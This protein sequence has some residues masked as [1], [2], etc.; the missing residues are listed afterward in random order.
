MRVARLVLAFLVVML[1]VGAALPV[2]AQDGGVGFED[3]PGLQSAISRTW[4]GELQPGVLAGETP[5]LR[6]HGKPKVALMLVAVFA[7]DTEANATAAWQLLQT[8]MNATG[9]SGQSL[10]LTP[11][12]LPLD[13]QYVAAS[14]IDASV[15]PPWDFTLVSAVDGTF[16]YTVIAITAGAPPETDAA[17][18]V[19]SLAA[20]AAGTDPVTF[21]AD[22]TSTGGLWA[23]VPTQ[24]AVERHFR[25]IVETIDAAPFPV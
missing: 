1:A 4:N 13:V 5:S 2:A 9:L 18:I 25:G 11:I 6:D 24:A 3:M 7:F 15:S 10:P 14:A 23:K 20:T 22:G 12:E 16:V 17:A 19:R 8:D 21:S